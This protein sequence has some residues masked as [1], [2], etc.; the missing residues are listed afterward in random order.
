MACNATTPELDRFQN[1]KVSNFNVLKPA[2]PGCIKCRL[3]RASKG[4]TLKGPPLQAPSNIR[5]R[6]YDAKDKRKRKTVGFA[7]TYKP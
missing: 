7:H 3:C 4:K 1:V 2:A 5:E 6:F